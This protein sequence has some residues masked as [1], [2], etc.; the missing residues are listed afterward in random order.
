[1]DWLAFA[2][3]GEP[4]LKLFRA[5]EDTVVRLVVDASASLDDAPEG[6][7]PIS[8]METAKRL[9]AAIGY[10]AI[11]GSERA[12]V[13]CAGG[14]TDG[15]RAGGAPTRGRAALPTLLSE[16]DAI[17]PRGGTDLARA[18]DGVVRRSVRPGML[19]IVSDFFDPGP[20]D[21]AIARAAQA[22]HDVGLVQVLSDA[23]LHPPYEGDLA[24]EDAETGALVEVTLDAPALAAYAERLNALILALRAIA[25]RVGATYVR[26]TTSEPLLPVVRRFVNRAVD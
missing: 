20:F 10:M 19:V 11:A 14:T 26:A 4:M 2:R 6:A 1:L 7:P 16:L 23:E 8:K 21:Q 25:K 5:E 12:Q 18:V 22:G 3:T 9:S 24:F 15:P 13:F 17:S